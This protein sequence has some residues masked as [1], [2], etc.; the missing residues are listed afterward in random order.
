[1]LKRPFLFEEAATTHKN[2]KSKQKQAKVA[3][4]VIS[5]H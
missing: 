5:P 2:A 3:D 4:K 1:V